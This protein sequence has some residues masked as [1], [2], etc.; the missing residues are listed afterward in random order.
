MNILFACI[1]CGQFIQTD[2][3]ASFFKFNCP[4]CKTI[5]SVP[6]EN[7]DFVRTITPIPANEIIASPPKQTFMVNLI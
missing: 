4:S 7:S 3:I 2:S 5:I 6:P 1:H